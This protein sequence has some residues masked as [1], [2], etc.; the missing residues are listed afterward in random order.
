MRRRL[1]LNYLELLRFTPGDVIECGVGY[2]GTSL[3]MALWLLENCPDKR[4]FACDTFSGLPHD[5]R[6]GQLRA[7]E[8]NFG[9]AFPRCVDLLPLGNVRVIRGRIEDTLPK[10]TNAR[11]CFAFLDLDLYLSTSAAAEWLTDR[12]VTGGILGFHDYGFQRT[13]GV[14]DVVDLEIDKT[15]FRRIDE[16]HNCVFFARV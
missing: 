5:E 6:R 14:D 1:C 7:G 13:P 3:P 12:M 9:E 15:K 16:G 8:W 10:L 2:G 11:F 4:L